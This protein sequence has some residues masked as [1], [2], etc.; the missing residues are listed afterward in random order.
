MRNVV[1]LP[2]PDGPSRAKNSPSA[3]ARSIA[4][5]ATTSP[6]RFVVP[7]IPTAVARSPIDGARSVPSAEITPRGLARSSEA[8][9]VCLLHKVEVRED[10]EI[11]DTGDRPNLVVDHLQELCLIG[12]EH[13]G[14]DVVAAGGDDQ[15]VDG[16]DLGELVSDIANVDIDVDAHHR[17]MSQSDHRRVGDGD[18]LHHPSLDQPVHSLPRRGLAEAHP[19]R[20][21]GVR[22]P[23]IDLKLPDDR[24]VRSVDVE[25]CGHESVTASPG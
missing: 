17:Q 6:K 23:P 4:S 19:W 13:L 12:T 18:D 11:S 24:S 1:V 5:T 14:Q 25:A 10:L 8:P 3:I 22:Q 7:V 16:V 15:I 20:K 21:F 9:V 2:Q